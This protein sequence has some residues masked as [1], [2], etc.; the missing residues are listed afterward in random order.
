VGNGN[1]TDPF[2]GGESCYAIVEL[3]LIVEGLPDPVQLDPYELCDDEA[4][5]SNTDQRSYFDLT[6]KNRE[7]TGGDPT[8]TVIWFATPEDELNDNPIADPTAYLNTATPE[9]VVARVTNRAGCESLITLTLVVIPVPEV[10]VPEPLVACDPDGDGYAPFLLHEADE[11]I[12]IGNTDLVVTYHP[13][14]SDARHA[15]NEIFDPY[16]N[17]DPWN[18]M[19]YARV[20]NRNT[21]CFTIVEVVLQVGLSPDLTTPEPYVLCEATIG[22]GTAVFNLPS[23]EEEM[24][25]GADPDLFDF[26]YYEEEAEAIA[27]GEA[28]RTNPNYTRAIG[29]PATY[30]NLTNPQIIYVLAVGNANY[31]DPY[32][33]G[34]GC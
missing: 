33:G 20:E 21:G 16:I 4:S 13:T 5:G 1:Y 19:V 11:E 3:E 12:T 24:L 6:S 27:A 7:I 8:L 23:K 34:E 17:D 25:D 18:D 30:T 26:Y 14:E 2:N 22:D 10:A 31:T 29:N 15:L 28:A 9:T 32:N